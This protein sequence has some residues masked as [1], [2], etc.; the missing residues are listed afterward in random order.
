MQAAYGL[1][2]AH[3]EGL[4]HRDVKPANILL[5]KGRNTVKIT[6]FGLA[7]AAEDVH[8]TQSGMVAGTPVY[9]APEQARG[10]ELDARTDLFSLGSVLYTLCT[11]V[12]PFDGNTPFMVLR[13]ITDESPRPIQEINPDVPDWLVEIIDQLLAKDPADRFQSASEVGRGAGDALDRPPGRDGARPRPPRRC[14]AAIGR[15]RRGAGGRRGWF[16]PAVAVASW[17]LLAGL[18]SLRR[19]PA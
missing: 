7:R 9:M 1:A 6:D 17:L 5:E 10:E 15:S 13:R 2:A 16:W 3:A 14:G 12:A 19:R 18:H 8:L 4:I 11:G